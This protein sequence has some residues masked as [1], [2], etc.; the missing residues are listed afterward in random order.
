MNPPSIP[1]GMI[2]SEAV[3]CALTRL[4][5]LCSYECSY[6][7]T[8]QYATMVDFF[9]VVSL[10]CRYLNWAAVKVVEGFDW[11]LVGRLYKAPA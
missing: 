5:F 7:A 11:N 2:C 3:S 9:N 1:S 10:Y 6:V 4:L 8:L